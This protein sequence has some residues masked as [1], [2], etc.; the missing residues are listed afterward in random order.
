MK[1]PARVW[2]EMFAGLLAYDD[3]AE[4]DRINTPTL[5]LWGD[6][7]GLVDRAM[8]VTLAER[9]HGAELLVYA[10]VG[11][12]AHHRTCRTIRRVRSGPPAPPRTLRRSGL[13]GTVISPDH[14]VTKRT[15]DGSV[16]RCSRRHTSR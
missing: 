4:I 13:P 8:Q 12:S 3:L 5:L 16:A 6:A 1:V 2:K 10:A 15:P 11:P 14:V 7:D 9:I